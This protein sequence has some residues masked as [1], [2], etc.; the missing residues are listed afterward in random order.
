VT[1]QVR[2]PDPV[3]EKAYEMST[4]KDMSIG[5]AIRLMCRDGVE[6]DV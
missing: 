5:E 4:D 3:Y 6:H 2:V 1:E